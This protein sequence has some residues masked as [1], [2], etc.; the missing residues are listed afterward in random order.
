MLLRCLN[1]A[2]AIQLNTKCNVLL[3]TTQNEFNSIK[4]IR[5]YSVNLKATPNTNLLNPRRFNQNLNVLTAVRFASTEFTL[6]NIPDAPKVPDEFLSDAAQAL[7]AGIEPGFA[8]Y[9][10]G[11]WTPVGIVQNI[12]E[13]LHIGAEIPWWGCIM[14]G[15]VC[16]RTIIFPLVIMAQRNGAKMNN[17]LPQLQVL[18]LKMTEARQSGNAIDSARYAQEMVAFMKD[19]DLNPLKNML[20]PLA[21]A[22]LFISFFMGL[23][24][25]ANA[26]VESMATG[27]LFWFTDLTVPDQ[28]YLLPIITS[29][30]MYLTIELG[31]DS[32][33]LSAQNLQTM[34]YVLR[35]LPFCILPFTVNFP[36]AILAYWTFSNFISLGQVGI[37]KIPAVRDYFK[38]ERLVVHKAEDMPV[39]KKGFREGLSD[40]WTN[41]KITRELEERK[42]MDEIIFQKAAKGAITKTYKYD[43]TKPRPPT[44]E[45]KK[46]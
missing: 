46:R 20:V 2:K 22:P 33:R 16:V 1:S 43:P 36:G 40:S 45:A 9:G 4:Q 12:M 23:R 17:N 42:R 21:Q 27:G 19:R 39:K 13:Y 8:T 24:Q 14:I 7:A 18:Q 3:K 28:F 34:K 38:I 10:L 26:P 31:T 25:M 35:A 15:T 11:G 5:N 44:V 29:I 37:L 41:M 32:A 30:T 6:D